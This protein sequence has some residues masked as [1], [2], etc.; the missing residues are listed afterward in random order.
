MATVHEPAADLRVAQGLA[1]EDPGRVTAQ[2]H[3]QHADRALAADVVEQRPG[4]VAGA[5]A[6]HRLVE[7]R[8]R[9]LAHHPLPVGAHEGHVAVADRRP[10]DVLV[11][12]RPAVEPALEALGGQLVAV[13]GQAVRFAE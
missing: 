5:I 13:F 4:L 9:R 3:E 6:A 10:R 2:A 1:G 11:P 7:R 8:E 12:R